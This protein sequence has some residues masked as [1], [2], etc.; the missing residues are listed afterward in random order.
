M[1]KPTKNN[2]LTNINCVIFELS[3]I[4]KWKTTTAHITDSTHQTVA[5]AVALLFTQNLLSSF[6]KL[7][8]I[9]AQ[10]RLPRHVSDEKELIFE[11]I[12][13]NILLL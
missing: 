13:L 3:P 9:D 1:P 8:K 11:S 5:N 12:I 4:T 7:L 10:C 2:E 6:S